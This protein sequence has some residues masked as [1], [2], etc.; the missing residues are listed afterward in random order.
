MYNKYVILGFLLTASIV[1]AAQTPQPKLV[2]GLVVDQMRQDYIYRYEKKFGA[3]GFKRFLNQGFQLT[4]LHYNYAATETGPGH[5]SIYTGTTPAIHGIIKNEW[6][7]KDTKGRVNCVATDAY[8][9]IGAT[10]TGASPEL[11][12]S[13]TITDELKIA[14]QRKGKVVSVSLKDRGAVLPGGHAADAAYWM[15]NQ[16]GNFITSSY[17]LQQL[18]SWANDF[19]SKKYSDKFA[20]MEWN[21]TLPL[22]Q[23]T[24]S[25]PDQSNCEQ[26]FD[27]KGVTFPHNLAEMKKAS[28]DYSCVSLSP[29][30]N[31]IVRLFA[32]SAIEGEKLG[33]D[34][35][36][37]FLAISF[38]S[39][40]ILGHAV[41]PQAVEIEDMYLQLDKQ[42]AELF[43][44]LDKKVGKGN[45][46]VFL[47]ADHAADETR[48]SLEDLKI[49]SGFLDLKKLKE[50]LNELLA[51]YFPGKE[52]VESVANDQIYINHQAFGD[53]LRKSALDIMICEEL[54][55][56][57]LRKQE[58]IAEAYPRS[59]LR[60]IPFDEK[61]FRGQLVR[62]Y[63]TERGGDIMF[64][65]KPQWNSHGNKAGTTHGTPYSYNTHV[66]GL[67]YG[68]GIKHGKSSQY[69]TITD[70][71]PTISTLVKIKFP[72]ACT[73]TPIVEILD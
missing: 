73:G 67:F 21:P 39:T 40:D 4:N 25:T 42:L 64:L 24:E 47:T 28:N 20:A 45:Y 1:V 26:A 59:V 50:G 43:L 23:Y 19:N 71:A 68:A 15:D 8:K 5:S 30:G 41:G 56:N 49:P 57:Y 12:L 34:D 69:H 46:T 22:E 35:I 29:Y 10:G 18:P 51:P 16:T 66:P 3:D 52:V 36:L 63:H 62:S 27:K 38:S 70:I 14:T 72:S 53:D 58:G 54:I 60:Q 37:D 61:S 11:L 13:T 33:S 2:V 9:M 17:Y 44:F 65:V 48:Q 6:F 7:V 31:E 32:Q 55:S